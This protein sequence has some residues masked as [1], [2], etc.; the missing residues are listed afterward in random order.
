MPSAQKH[1]KGPS[2]MVETYS[3]ST[4]EQ[5]AEIITGA[6]CEALAGEGWTLESS[7]RSPPSFTAF[8][9][10]GIAP[11]LTACQHPAHLSR[12][13]PSTLSHETI[14]DSS[15]PGGFLRL[16]LHLSYLTKDHLIL[17]HHLYP[18]TWLLSAPEGYDLCTKLCAGP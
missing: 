8:I 15:L 14:L 5:T 18:C 16:C 10:C 6:R 4:T 2:G 17:F 12:L 11:P 1:I 7:S 13:I 3:R 9:P